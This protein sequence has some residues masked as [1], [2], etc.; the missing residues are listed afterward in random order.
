[1]SGV[2]VAAIKIT[3][4]NSVGIFILTG[5]SR[6]DILDKAFA[7]LEI[8]IAELEKKAEVTEK[9]EQGVLSP[10]LFA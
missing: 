9:I 6:Q 7:E 3:L 1:M 8:K 2:S 10:Y 4:K 5:Q